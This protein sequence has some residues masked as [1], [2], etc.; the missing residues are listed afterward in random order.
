[1]RNGDDGCAT[2][3]DRNTACD[4]LC[5]ACNSD[6]SRHDNADDEGR[7]QHLAEDNDRYGEHDRLS[8]RS[9]DHV[10]EMEIVEELIA[11]GRRGPTYTVTFCPADTT[12]SRRSSALSNSEAAAR[13]FF[14][15]SSIFWSQA[16]AARWERT[17]DRDELNSANDGVCAR[18]GKGSK[19]Q[20]TTMAQTRT[21]TEESDLANCDKAC[22]RGFA[23]YHQ[24]TPLL[25]INSHYQVRV[26][27]QSG[28]CQEKSQTIFSMNLRN[29]VSDNASNAAG[30]CLSRPERQCR[31]LMETIPPVAAA[32]SIELI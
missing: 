5:A 4:P 26:L 16:P 13:S 1:M 24:Y 17:D 25:A 8:A 14:T 22:V 10:F 2:D 11:P 15:I 30:A 23:N 32:I 29:T 9:D 7:L 28:F 21:P 19:S 20:P 27:V 12:F 3:T 6:G 31:Q 18:T